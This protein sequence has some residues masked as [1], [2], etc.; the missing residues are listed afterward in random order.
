MGAVKGAREA[1]SGLENK[2][3]QLV[4]PFS[5]F[6]LKY[7]AF[8]FVETLAVLGA[9]LFI[10]ELSIVNGFV[11]PAYY[12]QSQARDAAEELAE[13][14]QVEEALI[15]SLCSYVVFDRDGAVKSG[16][17][18]EQSIAYAWRAVQEQTPKSGNYYYEVIPREG[19]YCVLQYEILPQY[20][21]PFLRRCLPNPQTLLLLSALC[22]FLL[23]ILLTA[24]RFGRTMKR[25]L[26]P[27]ISVTEEIQKQELDFCVSQSDI[28][29]I[30][31]VLGAMDD[32]RK[33]LKASL[34]SQWRQEQTKK[35]QILALAHDLKTPLTLVRGN[36]ELLRDTP[37]D[38]EQRECLE[39]VEKGAGRM[40]RYVQTLIEVTRDSYR[41]RLQ[42]VALASF[43]Q[44]ALVQLQM[45]CA[46]KGLL[47]QSDFSWEMPYVQLDRELFLRAL[48]N[49]FSNAVEYTD[50]GG[51]I[52][53]EVLQH[54][55]ELCFTVTDTGCGFSDEA[56]KRATEQFFTGD[57]SR[58]LQEHVGIGLYMAECVV[59][60]HGGRL[61]L[62]NSDRTGGAR[63]CIS[64]CN[65]EAG[66]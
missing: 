57:Q 58:S 61:G 2:K 13:A 62:E 5:F 46:G 64:L 44:E 15:P 14:V 16:N 22:A 6:Y 51:T 52:F 20:R 48:I 11:Y 17:I 24:F 30:N 9:V 8:L 19:E 3:K 10:F 42:R 43:A 35:E 29:E 7:F 26:A 33:A 38:E 39:V 41:L 1:L 56:L 65:S 36:A 50:A 45:L 66:V 21:S 63:V 12:A 49:V 31:A 40:Q 47:T 37:L 32:M 60:Q 18:K 28:R 27:L 55:N 34:E 4:I 25:K 54:E 23:I 59:K 53:F